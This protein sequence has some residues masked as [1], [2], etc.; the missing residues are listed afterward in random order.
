MTTQHP[1]LDLHAS[2]P[3]AARRPFFRF[4]ASLWPWVPALLLVSLLGT[5]LAVLASA[6]DDPSFAAEPDYY[7]KALDWD[8]RQAAVRDSRALG[9]T[10]RVTAGP[11]THA[12]R[13]VSLSLIDAHGAPVSGAIVRAIAFA[14]ARSTQI[15]ELT[16]LEAAP[17][18]YR[19]E[20]G[21][22][23]LGIWELRCTA[24]REKQR[25]ET[26]LRVELE[27]AGDEP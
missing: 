24:T 27:D 15:R 26:T 1:A 12:S 20:L 23:R 19:A 2:P 11:A 4:R 21:P 13:A 10:A 25:F 6:L 16:F 9:W 17:G 14:N 5:Q 22:A 18:I 3:G 7:R 8:A